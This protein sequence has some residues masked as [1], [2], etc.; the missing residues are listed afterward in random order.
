METKKFS[1]GEAIGYAL[2]TFIDHFMLF[3][4]SIL[5]AVRIAPARCHRQH[6]DFALTAKFLDLLLGG[7]AEFV[8]LHR[9][10]LLEFAVAKNLHADA[11]AL[12]NIA[13]GQLFRTDFCAIIENVQ[14]LDVD[15]RVVGRVPGVVE[16]AARQANNEPCLAA[17]EADFETT[18]GTRGLT[19]AAA[20]GCL[21]VAAALAAAQPFDTVHSTRPVF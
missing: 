3:F 11:L 4:G 13:L 19:L 2:R 7:A 21:A 6:D 1:I 15:N 18:A 12:Q 14:S 16:S 20:G 10:L 5:V 17:L 8:G 9:Q